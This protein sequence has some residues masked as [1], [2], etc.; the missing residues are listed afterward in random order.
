MKDTVGLGY[1]LSDLG[2]EWRRPV[3][4]DDVAFLLVN[5][6]VCFQ[7]ALHPRSSDWLL[8]ITNWVEDLDS[9]VFGEGPKCL[10]LFDQDAYPVVVLLK[11]DDG[12][13]WD[14]VVCQV[15]KDAASVQAHWPVPLLRK[16]FEVALESEWPLLKEPAANARLGGGRYEG[17][18]KTANERLFYSR[19]RIIV[20]S[21]F[22]P[23]YVQ[24]LLDYL[25]GHLE[26]A[27]IR[28]LKVEQILVDGR[29]FVVP[30]G[31]EE[32][33][34]PKSDS[35]EWTLE[36]FFDDLAKTRGEYAV[37]IANSLVE[38][39][40]RSGMSLS[41]GKGKS[42][43]SI[44]PALTHNGAKYKIVTI[45]SAGEI[46]FLFKDLAKRPPFDD[47]AL[48]EELVSKLEA[49]KG[50]AIRKGSHKKYPSLSFARMVH[51]G[52]VEQ[53]VGVLDWV[54]EKIKAG[55]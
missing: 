29:R 55:E 31:S 9:E 7:S 1:G 22:V 52:A 4:W 21:E 37:R 19:V 53:L 54:V 15:V 28:C 18:W 8:P 13:S 11:R 39:A 27:E 10:L 33:L 43:G 47:D 24:F 44:T 3:D 49:I 30:Q 17:F 32:V 46:Q 14:E 40:V 48:L 35:G 2:C 42:C 12:H 41:M 25:N 36:M 5:F 16:G 51:E 20:I 26:N 50:I 34:Q 38:W 6:P 23:D 45:W